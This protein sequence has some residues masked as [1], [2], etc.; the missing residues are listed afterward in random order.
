VISGKGDDTLQGSSADELFV[1]RTDGGLTPIA[2]GSDVVSSG[3]GHDTLDFTN[4]PDG[5]VGH[6]RDTTRNSVDYVEIYFKEGDAEVP[7]N[8][9]LIAKPA[10]GTMDEFKLRGNFNTATLVRPT[11]TFTVSPLMSESAPTGLAIT[12]VP[13]GS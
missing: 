7:G 13:A 9:V 11:I 12:Q 5:W 4:V 10:A 2:W 1:F 3:G 6:F 8:S